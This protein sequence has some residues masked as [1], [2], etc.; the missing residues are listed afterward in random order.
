VPRSARVGKGLDRE[1]ACVYAAPVYEERSLTVPTSDENEREQ[2]RMKEKRA[3]GKRVRTSVSKETRA[4]GPTKGVGGQS[5][6]V[7]GPGARGQ[8]DGSNPM[9]SESRSAESE[10]ARTDGQ[11]SLV[12]HEPDPS[13]F[14]PE[15]MGF[16]P[17]EMPLDA[18][19]YKGIQLKDVGRDKKGRVIQHKYSER[20]AKQIAGW[21]T[22]GYSANAICC[23][24]NMR[25]GKLK[26]LYGKQIA[27]GLELVGMD[28][29]SHI[30]KRAKTSDRMAIFFAKAKLGWRDGESRPLDSGSLL[31]IHIHM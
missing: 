13:V 26:E 21:I 1:D 5:E 2:V 28:M 8:Y 24:I 25:P 19:D 31:N 15:V 4:G 16:V 12:V 18:P 17:T 27:M 10:S 20:Q 7:P 23:A 30:L 22:S 6:R 29:T 3:E 14:E 9:N 11:S